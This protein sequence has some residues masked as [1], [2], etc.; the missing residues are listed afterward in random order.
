MAASNTARR[1][2][3][4][5]ISHPLGGESVCRH[6]TLEMQRAH[7]SRTAREGPR[8]RLRSSFMSRSSSNENVTTLRSF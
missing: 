2:F 4:C 3:G 8:F 5:L 7:T 1:N 6:W